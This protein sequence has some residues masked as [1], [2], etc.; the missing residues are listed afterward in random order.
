MKRRELLIGGAT[1]SVSTAIAVLISLCS[2]S[3]LAHAENLIV[4]GSSTFATELMIPHQTAIE[5]LAGHSLKILSNRSDLGLLRLLSRNSNLAMISTSLPN[6]V[7][8]LRQTYPEFPYDRLQSFPILRTHIAFAVHLSNPVRDA[9]LST[10]KKILSGEISNWNQ[11][12]GP[13]LPIR[14][15]FVQEGGVALTVW[16]EIFGGI[17][18]AVA[19]AIRVRYGKEVV[20]V[21]EQEPAALGI[22]QRALVQEHG[23]A[24]LRTDREIEQELNLVTFG[25]PTPAERAVIDATRSVARAESR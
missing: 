25:E 12:G 13:D 23:L 22:A 16:Q 4:Q 9:D 1:R 21:V 15:V 8:S 7:S 5:S 17:Q 6:V 19:P 2:A 20:K 24:E 14:T 18:I 10:I 11:L 3:S